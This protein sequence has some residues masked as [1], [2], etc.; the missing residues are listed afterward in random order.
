MTFPQ[1]NSEL[2]FFSRFLYIYVKMNTFQGFSSK[3]TQPHHFG[4]RVHGTYLK[5][6]EPYVYMYIVHTV[7]VMRVDFW[8]FWIFNF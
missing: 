1:A 8:I 3:S 7:P 6:S 4:S 2:K 5:P